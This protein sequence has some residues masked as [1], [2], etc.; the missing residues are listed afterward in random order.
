MRCYTCLAADTDIRIR[1]SAVVEELRQ[2]IEQVEHQPEDV[3]RRIAQLITE[4]L[5]EQEW[6][7]LVASPASQRFL[8]QL[9]A[10]IDA[11]VAAGEVEEGGWEL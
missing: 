4:Q 9:S 10:S 7:E 2:A 3:Q 6:D 11:Q 1:G 5:E 8:A